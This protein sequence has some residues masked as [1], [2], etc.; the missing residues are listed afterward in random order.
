MLSTV[1]RQEICI[2]NAEDLFQ[3]CNSLEEKNWYF[4]GQRDYSWPLKTSLERYFEENSI[5]EPREKVNFEKCCVILSST[6]LESNFHDANEIEKLA[7]LQH[8]GAPT[9]LL[10]ITESFK[11]AL[12]FAFENSR[13]PESEECALFVFNTGR[14]LAVLDE[15]IA[16][17][18]EKYRDIVAGWSTESMIRRLDFAQRQI[19]NLKEI[20]GLAEV[21]EFPSFPIVPSNM[22]SSKRIQNQKGAFMLCSNIDKSAEENFWINFR[23]TARDYRESWTVNELEHV[24]LIHGTLSF[25]E[26]EQKLN[27]ISAA[28]LLKI[29]IPW[30][31]RDEI[32]NRV[33]QGEINRQFIYPS[34]EETKW[35]INAKKI[36][37]LLRLLREAKKPAVT[38]PEVQGHK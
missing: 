30:S 3:I 5:T 12:W 6:V 23:L 7:I 28:S 25:E 21:V 17:Y 35:E 38:V 15:T 31:F 2:S 26:F 24:G 11:I 27:V 20:A 8:Y 18:C 14:E 1:W 22:A 13:Q 9:R 32:L 16:I 4:R 36:P 34:E 19:K 33:E 10:D 29:R 37:E